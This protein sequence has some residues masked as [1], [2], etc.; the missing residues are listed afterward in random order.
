MYGPIYYAR[1]H[2][3]ARHTSVAAGDTNRAPIA[4]A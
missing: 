1:R 4:F 3:A 2:C